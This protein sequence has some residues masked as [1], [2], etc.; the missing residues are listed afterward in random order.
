M[1][2]DGEPTVVNPRR[3]WGLAS[4][5][6]ACMPAVH[7]QVRTPAPLPARQLAV[8]APLIPALPTRGMACLRSPARCAQTPGLT[9]PSSPPAPAPPAECASCEGNGDV[10]FSTDALEAITGYNWDRKVRCAGGDGLM[11]DKEHAALTPQAGAAASVVCEGATWRSVLCFAAAGGPCRTSARPLRAPA[12]TPPAPPHPRPLACSASSGSGLTASRTPRKPSA[13]RR[14]ARCCRRE[15]PA[16]PVPPGS[17]AA[18]TC[19]RP[20][21]PC[22]NPR[23]CPTSSPHHLCHKL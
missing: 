8:A 16:L 1:I 18:R 20:G 12:L 5:D 7:L 6:G 22:P 2:V 11:R 9:T 3:A 13:P 14:T 21:A 19:P 10:D 23:G 4:T 15:A 17:P